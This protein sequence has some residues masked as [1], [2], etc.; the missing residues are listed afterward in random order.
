MAVQLLHEVPLVCDNKNCPDYQS[1]ELVDAKKIKIV[2]G[3]ETLICPSCGTYVI[4][5]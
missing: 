1:F 3:L 5:R 2:G 4:V